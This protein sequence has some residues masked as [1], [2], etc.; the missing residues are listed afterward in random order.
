MKVAKVEYTGRVRNQSK[1]GPTGRRYRFGGDGTASVD[2]LEDAR[3]FESATNFEVEFTA[4]GRLMEMV[5]G[6]LEDVEEAVSELDYNVKRSMASKLGLETDGSE[7]S[8]IED[9]LADQAERLQAQ[10]ERQR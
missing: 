5:S 9:A 3:H 4:R 10:M 6:D 8:V 2:S 7:E 1:R